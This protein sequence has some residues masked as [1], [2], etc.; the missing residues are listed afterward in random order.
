MDHQLLLPFSPPLPPPHPA[1]FPSS[2]H[3]SAT[4]LFPSHALCPAVHSPTQPLFSHFPNP[5]L[6]SFSSSFPLPVLCPPPS[7]LFQP[8]PSPK[9]SPLSSVSSCS[10][11]HNG[12]SSLNSIFGLFAF[13]LHTLQGVAPITGVPFTVPG[14]Q[15]KPQKCQKILSA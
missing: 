8:S 4:S 6:D 7:R 1:F 5:S 2:P 3:H 12:P 15:Q 11:L 9:P 10:L 13:T 14:T